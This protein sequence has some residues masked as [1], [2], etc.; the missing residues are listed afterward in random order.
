VQSHIAEH[1]G[2]D[3]LTP[4]R[5]AAQQ[6]ISTRYLHKLFELEG[7]SV[8]AWIRERRL[9]GCCRDL[10]DPAL[11]DRTIA[12]IARR[13]G[14]PDAARLGRLVRAAHGCSPRELRRRALA[15]PPRQPALLIA[16]S[17]PPSIAQPTPLT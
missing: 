4:E 10:A 8:A 6:F 5:I 14:L 11:A 9:E 16:A 13:W 3:T 12:D 7:I 15:A 17:T 1:L 2:D